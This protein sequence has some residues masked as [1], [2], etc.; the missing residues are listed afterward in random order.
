[1]GARWPH[2][3]GA[4]AR[5]GDEGWVEGRGGGWR[6]MSRAFR[7]RARAVDGRARGKGVN[8]GFGNRSKRVDGRECGLTMIPIDATG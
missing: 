3:W 7:A 1:M 5:V 6:K 2:L 4:R 8:E